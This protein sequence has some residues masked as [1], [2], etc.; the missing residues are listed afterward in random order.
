[1]QVSFT[2]AMPKL[3]RFS[4]GSQRAKKKKVEQ[5]KEGEEESDDVENEEEAAAGPSHCTIPVAELTARMERLARIDA[6]MAVTKEVLTITS[7]H[8]RLDHN[9]EQARHAHEV[10]NRRWRKTLLHYFSD[11]GGLRWA[12]SSELKR[13]LERMQDIDNEH[14]ASEDHVLDCEKEKACY[15]RWSRLRLRQL[16]GNED[17]EGGALEEAARELEVVRASLGV[18]RERPERKMEAGQVLEVIARHASMA[19]A[20][21]WVRLSELRDDY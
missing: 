8:E 2:A 7:E 12:T 16:T 6:G 11:N 13:A 10:V 5:P 14:D 9:L 4:V 15:R 19:E 1:M 21:Q 20:F 18:A 3:G 17:V